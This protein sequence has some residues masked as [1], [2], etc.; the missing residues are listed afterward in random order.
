MKKSRK[1]RVKTIVFMCIFSATLIAL[2]F[3]IRTRTIPF[4]MKSVSSI[5]ETERLLA[6]D[7][8]NNY[9]SS[10]REVLKLYSRIT[11]CLYNEK[12][13]SEQ[14][15]QLANQLRQLFDEELLQ[16]NPTEN[17]LS[18]L[19]VEI[20]GYRKAN[21]SIMN[22]VIENSD[23]VKYWDKEKQNYA[24][25]VMSFTTKEKNDYSKI[26]EKFLFRKDTENNWK[27]LGWKLTDKKEIDVSEK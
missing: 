18:D 1:Q 6:K 19:N 26:F 8:A 15:E 27:I 20:T 23:S 21:R 10:P 17:Y 22:Y 9:P 14:T 3:F 12:L 24:S 13:T 7:I 25:S 2:Y 16:N 11:K 4:P 5:S